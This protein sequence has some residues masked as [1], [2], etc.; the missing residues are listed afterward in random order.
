LST[1]KSIL[2]RI[3]FK[4]ISV[5]FIGGDEAFVTGYAFSWASISTVSEEIFAR[6]IR[7]AFSYSGSLSGSVQ[8][9]LVF[10]EFD[11]TNVKALIALNQKLVIQS[12]DEVNGLV[13]NSI[14]DF[15]ALY[16]EY[17]SRCGLSLDLL[18]LTSTGIIDIELSSFLAFKSTQNVSTGRRLSPSDIITIGVVSHTPGSIPSEPLFSELDIVAIQT[19]ISTANLYIAYEI[20][21]MNS[22]TSAATYILYFFIVA[23]VCIASGVVVIFAIRQY[24]RKKYGRSWSWRVH[25]K[26][27]SVKTFLFEAFEIFTKICKKR[28]HRYPMAK[29]GKRMFYAFSQCHRIRNLSLYV[30]TDLWALFRA[31]FL[32]IGKSIFSPIPVM[33]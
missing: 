19:Q 22:G 20:E 27:D 7:S 5:R 28:N 11:A 12:N 33:S 29:S 4:D 9:G 1:K 15:I 17:P 31:V 32:R 24:H 10:F 2:E 6:H 25:D 21:K 26:L 30:T 3:E 13:V 18:S 8:E 23:V 16:C 14:G